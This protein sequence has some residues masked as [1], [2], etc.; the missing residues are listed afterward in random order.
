MRS[1]ENTSSELQTHFLQIRTVTITMLPVGR[2]VQFSSNTTI[3]A[4]IVTS[5]WSTNG[6]AAVE[7]VIVCQKCGM[8]LGSGGTRS[9]PVVTSAG[10][11]QTGRRTSMRCLQFI[12]VAI[13]CGRMGGPP[14]WSER[15]P[16]FE[17]TLEFLLWKKKY[18]KTV[19]QLTSQT[20]LR[21][22]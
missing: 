10:V 11:R 4:C 18:S 6:D 17:F 15:E 16:L 7:S 5:H 12:D 1:F 13:D 8:L 20:I 2:Y 22:V 14:P 19:Q 3:V 21:L 9:P